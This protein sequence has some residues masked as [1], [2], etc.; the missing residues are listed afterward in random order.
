MWD[1]RA[2]RERGS[3]AEAGAPRRL[4]LVPQALILPTQPIPFS[5][6]PRTV[7]FHAIPLFAQTPDFV[8]QLIDDFVGSARWRVAHAPVMPEF[9]R[10]YKSDPVTNYEKS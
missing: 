7:G 6:Q 5:L 3:L 10:Q 8:F 2:F 1:G 4:Q 9:Q